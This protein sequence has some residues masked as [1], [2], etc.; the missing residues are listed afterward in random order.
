VT[1]WTALDATRQPLAPSVGPF[2]HAGF[3]SAWWEHL[4]AGD[5][6]VVDVGG[7]AWAFITADGEV[8]AAGTA[9]LVDYRSPLGGDPTELIGSVVADRG[10]GTTFSFDSLPVEAAEAVTKALE[11]AGVATT[12]SPCAD[13]M[14][15]TLDGG[16]HLGGL[17]AKQRHEVRR[18]QRRFEEALGEAS[19]VDDPA[20]FDEF[21][22]LHR[23]APGDKGDFMTGE[24]EGFF[25]DLLV[26]PGVARLDCLVT[27]GDRLVAAG[28]GFEDADA[29]Y[30]YNSAYD[31]AVADVSPGI[32][33]LHHLIRRVNASGRRRFD[34]LKGTETYKRRLGAE[35]RPL[36]LVEGR[37]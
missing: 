25:R 20:R 28:F 29:Y 11:A 26:L 5:L 17:D 36:Y 34:F 32:V 27:A 7:A 14:V 19:L 6:E 3:L 37:L 13:T 30:L 2:P 33:L 22:A 35:P 15:L 24:M 18:K 4:G 9:D 21:V 16:D 1:D 10:S 8:T 12:T 23:A 31:P